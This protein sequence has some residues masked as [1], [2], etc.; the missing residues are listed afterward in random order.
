MYSAHAT[1]CRDLPTA[2][3]PSLVHTVSLWGCWTRRVLG[4]LCCHRQR[5]ERRSLGGSCAPVCGTGVRGGLLT[6][7][8]PIQHAAKQA[9]AS[10]TQTIAAAQHAASSNKNPAAQQQLVQSCK[11]RA[12]GLIPVSPEPPNPHPFSHQQRRG[13]V[14]GCSGQA[15]PWGPHAVPPGADLLVTGPGLGLSPPG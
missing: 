3:F 14:L 2:P 12:G 10:A 9:A 4:I 6:H 15:G 7:T 5:H 13:S 11:V 8:S 1:S